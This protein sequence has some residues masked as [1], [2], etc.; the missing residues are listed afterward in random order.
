MPAAARCHGAG[1]RRAGADAPAKST[2]RFGVVYIPMGAV[3][4]NWTPE[5]TGASFP[6]RPHPRA[7][8]R[9]SATA[10]RSC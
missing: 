3:M 8:G 9:G 5:E 10:A 6:L 2:A 7:I 1:A 4:N